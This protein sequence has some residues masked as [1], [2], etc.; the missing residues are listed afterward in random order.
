MKIWFTLVL[1]IVCLAFF[2]SFLGFPGDVSA[3]IISGAGYTL[4]FLMYFRGFG[5]VRMRAFIFLLATQL[6]G[7][8]WY[9]QE[10]EPSRVVV[11][12]CFQVFAAVILAFASNAWF[13]DRKEAEA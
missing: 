10:P 12:A 2:A 11:M 7:A 8:S 6:A 4:M 9:I 3:S 1:E 13:P 5:S